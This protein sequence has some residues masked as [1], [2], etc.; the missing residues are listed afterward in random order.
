MARHFKDYSL[1]AARRRPW[2][3]LLSAFSHTDPIHLA[4]NMSCLLSSAPWLLNRVGAESFLWFYICAAVASSAG[5]IAWRHYRREY[6]VC[7]LGASGVIYA[8]D[9]ASVVFQYDKHEIFV[10]DLVAT[11]PLVYMISQLVLEWLFM[12]DELDVAGHVSGALFGMV[13]AMW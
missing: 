2:T 1:R 6:G 13:W 11:S 12:S 8:I 10:G 5:S 7:S 4:L 3:L 9:A